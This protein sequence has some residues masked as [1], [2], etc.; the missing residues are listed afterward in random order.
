MYAACGKYSIDPPF[1]NGRQAEPPRRKLPD[2]Q[3]APF[4]LLDL[5]LD[6]VRKPI[7][8]RRKFLF[9]LWLEEV[10]LFDRNEVPSA[11]HRIE[12]HSMEIGDLDL[13]PERAQRRADGLEHGSVE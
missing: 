12:I 5:G 3:V 8:L 9:S 6:F 11:R 4:D 10:R 7:P 1:E 2:H 13:M